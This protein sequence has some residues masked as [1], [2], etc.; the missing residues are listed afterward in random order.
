MNKAI[1]MGRLVRD[2]EIRYTQGAKPTS[3]C[4]YRIAV[5]RGYKKDGEPDSD[6]FTC[7]AF[8]GRA[9]FVSKYFKK[10]SMI[11][12]VGQIQNRE[13]TAKDGTNRRETEII[14]TDQYFCGGKDQTQTQAHTD[15]TEYD[16]DDDLPFN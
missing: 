8:G 9:D 2:P 3:V 16:S 11:A 13:Y 4:R 1:L 12:V 10:G 6:F 14:V 7:V 5:S 15:F